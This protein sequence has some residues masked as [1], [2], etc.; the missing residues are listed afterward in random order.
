M[1]ICVSVDLVGAHDCLETMTLAPL[2]T[3]LG[4]FCANVSIQVTAWSFL[5]ESA[6]NQESTMKREDR[7]SKCIILRSLLWV[8]VLLW[9]VGGYRC[10]IANMQPISIYTRSRL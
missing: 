7:G 1:C 5:G 6:R 8:H 10:G 9:R 3:F 2:A 4:R